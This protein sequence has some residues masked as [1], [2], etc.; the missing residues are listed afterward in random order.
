[1]RTRRAVPSE[2]TN[3]VILRTREGTF[4][5]FFS[6]VARGK[7]QGKGMERG[8]VTPGNRSREELGRHRIRKK[9]RVGSLR[10]SPTSS[11][12]FCSPL[13]T[14]TRPSWD[15]L[16]LSPLVAAKRRAWTAS[17]RAPRKRLCKRLPPGHASP[18]TTT[19]SHPTGSPIQR[20]TKTTLAGYV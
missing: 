20:S 14:S 10:V 6:L 4:F 15:R 13:P 12:S 1:M 8:H 3:G 18:P 11:P 19:F 9:M 5:F 7:L 17:P 16:V 2:R